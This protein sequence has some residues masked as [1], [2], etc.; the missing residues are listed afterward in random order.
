MKPHRLVIGA[1]LFPVVLALASCQSAATPPAIGPLAAA[2][3]FHDP[4]LQARL[5]SLTAGFRGVAGVHVRNLRTGSTAQVNADETF[6]TASMIKVPLLVALFDRVERGEL[7]L[8]EEMVFHDSLRYAQ[9]DLTAKFRDGEVI[10][11]EQMAFL[12]VALSDNTASLWIQALVGGGGAVNEWLA[13]NGFAS[14]RVNSRTEGRR[15]DWER[16]G[17]GQ[18][19]P[20]EMARLMVMIRQGEAVSAGASDHMYRM[21]SRTFWDRTAL[22]PIPSSVQAASKQGFVSRSRSEVLLVNAPS[23]DYVLTVI[24]KEQEDTSS[25]SDNEGFRLIENVSAAVYE[26][27]E[28]GSQALARGNAASGSDRR[29]E[30]N[31]R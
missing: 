11:L 2:A 15:P 12:M 28:G 29:S 13:S 7:R 19:T 17:W 30:H 8:Q 16:Y 27:F 6:P 18:T 20:R 22:A 9:S 10:S 14:T 25:G 26:W 23:G 1:L 3:E 5:D 21:L 31:R 4:G 24:T